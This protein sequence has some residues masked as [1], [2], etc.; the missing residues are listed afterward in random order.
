[1]IDDV[2]RGPILPY[3]SQRDDAQLLEKQAR[4]FR[5]ID[6]CYRRFIRV[7]EIKERTGKIETCPSLVI[8]S[9]M[10]IADLEV[11]LG[12]ASWTRLLQMCPPGGI[13]DLTGVRNWRRLSRLK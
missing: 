5:V 6:A 7:Q 11:F 9:N 12:G 8:T 3:I 2:G 10:Q 4:Y 1:V 13:H